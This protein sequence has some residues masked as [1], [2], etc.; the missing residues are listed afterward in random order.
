MTTPLE[1]TA[2]GFEPFPCDGKRPARCSTWPSSTPFKAG[3]NV[4]LV[5]PVGAV[6][7]D[8][9]R[10][11]D[12]DGVKA[13]AEIAPTGW[14]HTGPRARTGGG[15]LHL[16]FRVS[17]MFEIGNGRGDLP[18]GIDIRGGAKGY[19]IAP[20][21]VH[22]ATRARYEW[23]DPLLPVAQ[24]PEVP[25]WLLK[26]LLTTPSAPASSPGTLASRFPGATVT[27]APD[28]YLQGALDSASERV[29]GAARG[30]R[31]IT[32]NQ[33]AYELAGLP[34]MD[35][36][37]AEERLFTAGTQAGL[38]DRE[39][40]ATI[41]S[42]FRAG[43][44]RARD[45]PQSEHTR[46]HAPGRGTQ[47]A[48]TTDGKP[49]QG[50]PPRGRARPAVRITT[51]EPGVNDAAIRALAGAEYPDLYQRTGE[52]VRVIQY[53]PTPGGADSKG[54]PVLAEGQPVITALTRST[55]QER[56]SGAA[57]WQRFD[58]RAKDWVSTH[59]P[60]WSVQ[61][62]Q[63]RGRWEGVPTL[64]GIAD[65]P[66][67]RPDGSMAT[68]PGYDP[69]TGFYLGNLPHGLRVPAK[70]TRD[71][72]RAASDR[73]LEL[74]CDFPLVD[75]TDRASWLALLLTP[76][77][78]A[79]TN[80][81]TPLFIASANVRGTGKTLIFSVPG[82]I[83]TGRDLPAQRYGRDD[84]EIEK[85]LVSVARLGLPVMLFDNVK[86]TIGGASL[87]KWLTSTSP[88]GRILGKSEV[89]L[90]DW[91]TVLAATSNNAAVS[92]DT[93]RRSI[94]CKQETEHE[95]PEERSGFRIP[96]LRE[97]V[98]EHRGELL[99]GA[100]CILRAYIQAGSPEQEGRPKG[101]FEAWARTVRDPLLWLGLPD[102]ERPPDDPARPVDS[103]REILG[104]L[105]AGLWE[106]FGG[107]E[108]SVAE[109][110]ETAW[111]SSGRDPYSTEVQLREALSMIAWKGDRPTRRALGKRLQ[112]FRGRWLSDMSLESR[113]DKH[114]GAQ[115]WRVNRRVSRGQ[116][117]L[118][119]P[120]T[121]SL[122]D[123]SVAR[124]QDTPAEPRQT[125]IGEE[126]F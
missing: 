91:T 77:A 55:L 96:R 44:Q 34:G 14:R 90:F 60:G 104:P 36:H 22:P 118:I 48:A 108:V 69:G 64:R 107:Q 78:R 97:H 46:S 74:V 54:R 76:L 70:P 35:L 99:S 122:S 9:D 38:T 121:R 56:L 109:I 73:L 80:G 98:L 43:S 45:I 103:D 19:V 26:R 68:K 93:D 86:T 8:L 63:D 16:W 49:S 13:L 85:V 11:P 2:L 126:V 4:G 28:H 71:D 72:A 61:A 125:R 17:P 79:I 58:A 52:L 115:R 1:Y 41:R 59:P 66:L 101:S 15:G 123:S 10:K 57:D 23:I 106:A 102:C 87:D 112:T 67:V 20:P 114:A 110:L 40:R 3:D 33:E 117:G 24:L 29:L 39:T 82:W 95:R 53:A 120:L 5:V 83:L 51:D 50:D 25:G 7:V 32:L 81:P 100:L 116:E 92:G 84:E 88:T 75:D 62:V 105:L 47:R 94:Y 31:N 18:P 89:V 12:A 124:G 119:Q 65:Y 111:P 27:E 42:A 113:L 37:W 21:S 30:Q 6:V